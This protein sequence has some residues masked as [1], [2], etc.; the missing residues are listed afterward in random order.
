VGAKLCKDC[1]HSETKFGDKPYEHGML[2]FCTRYPDLVD[3]SPSNCRDVRLAAIDSPNQ[4]RSHNVC[5]IMGM[6]WEEKDTDET[7]EKP[8]PSTLNYNTGKDWRV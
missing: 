5:G 3:G 8:V 7:L 6:G 2:L 4:S 1:K